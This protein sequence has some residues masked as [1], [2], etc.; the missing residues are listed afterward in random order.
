MRRA[1]TV[2]A[3]SGDSQTVYNSARQSL[4]P[5]KTV[6]ESPTRAWTV[7]APSQTVWESIACAQTYLATSQ[8]VWE[9]PA[10]A[11]T[12][13][14]PSQTVFVSLQMPRRSGRLSGSL[15]LVLRQ[16]WHRRRLSKSLLQVPRRSGENLSHR[17]GVSCR[18][19]D[20]LGTVTDCMRFSCLYPTVL[21]IVWHRMRVSCRRSDGLTTVTD[22][23]GVRLAPSWSL[24][25]VPRRSLHHRRL[26]ESFFAGDP[27]V[28][29]TVWHSLEFSCRSPDGFGTIVDFL[30]CPAGSPPV[31]ETGTVTHFMGVSCRCLAG[32]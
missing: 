6:W 5:S 7:L 13:L 25:Q 3:T 9:S 19:P 24:L 4:T 28:W 10:A 31:L 27:E 23:Q 2:W 8:T 12:I 14:A 15:R 16:S 20:G 21:Y 29:E 32:P 26:S 22:C 30:E 11:H 17:L 1:N 18:C